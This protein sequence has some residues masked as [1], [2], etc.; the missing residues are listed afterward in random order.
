MVSTQTQPAACLLQAEGFGGAQEARK[1]DVPA[2]RKSKEKI[3]SRKGLPVRV[4]TQTGAKARRWMKD[5]KRPSP[6]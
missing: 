4:R 2:V 5:L 3:V 6:R 1:A